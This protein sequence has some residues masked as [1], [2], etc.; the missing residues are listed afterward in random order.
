MDIR[1]NVCRLCSPA[2][3]VGLIFMSLLC[4]CRP[5][6]DPV[7]ISVDLKVETHPDTAMMLLDGYSLTHASSGADSAWYGLLL[8][9]LKYK[10]L[11]DETDDSLISHAADWF[12]CHGDDK[13]ASRALFLKGMIQLNGN[14]LGEAAV[15]FRKGLNIGR[16]S[17]FSDTCE[18][19]FSLCIKNTETFETYQVFSITVGE[20]VPLDLECG[21]YEVNA[22]AD[23]QD[24]VSLTGYMTVF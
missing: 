6:V 17:L 18:G 14:R 16:L 13:N 7:L 1:S 4:G 21:V 2:I 15:S 9:H 11:I 20:S 24:G 5:K 8:T 19:E 22:N 12:L 3:T 23:N 10:D